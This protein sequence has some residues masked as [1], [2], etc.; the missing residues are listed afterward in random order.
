SATPPSVSRIP[1]G[2]PISFRDGSHR[3]SSMLTRSRGTKTGAA[4]MRHP[5]RIRGPE[6]RP[7]ALEDRRR[8]RPRI[9]GSWPQECRAHRWRC[10]APHLPVACAAPIGACGSRRESLPLRP[11]ARSCLPLRFGDSGAGFGEDRS[12]LL[13][14]AVALACL[15]KPRLHDLFQRLQE[16]RGGGDEAGIAEGAVT[17][18]TYFDLAF[19]ST[20]RIIAHAGRH[21][22]NAYDAP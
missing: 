22:R 1:C 11:C 5:S 10:G 19:V 21:L 8:C 14:D 13:H 2:Y 18:G 9:A 4:V 12:V 15:V 6:G 20:D 7:R 16:L 3:R 17:Q